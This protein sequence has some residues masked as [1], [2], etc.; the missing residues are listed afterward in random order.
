M[1]EGKASIGLLYGKF[2]YN[3]SSQTFLRLYLTYVRPHLE[4]VAA[5]W[6]PHQQGLIRKRAEVC[7][8]SLH[9]KLESWLKDPYQKL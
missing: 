4:Y 8:Q 6:D 1:Q 5:V 3:A 9:K 2:Y 7:F